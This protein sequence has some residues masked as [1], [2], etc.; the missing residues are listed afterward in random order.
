MIL[1]D[2]FLYLISARLVRL[3]RKEFFRDSMVGDAITRLSL[4]VP[5]RLEIRLHF[6]A[7][8]R[9]N[10]SIQKQL[11]DL[12]ICANVTGFPI[13]LADQSL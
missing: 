5:W 2:G 7:Y 11:N 10:L 12:P 3:I 9:E 6:A 13:S 1:A 4:G 8:K